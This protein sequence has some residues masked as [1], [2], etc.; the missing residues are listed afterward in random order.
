MKNIYNTNNWLINNH[1]EMIDRIGGYN[2]Q[3]TTKIYKLWLD[4][5]TVSK[6]EKILL[7]LSK[8]IESNDFR[9]NHNHMDEEFRIETIRN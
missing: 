8:Y 3:F 2:E 9:L 5:Y 6:H 7:F 1:D 4:E